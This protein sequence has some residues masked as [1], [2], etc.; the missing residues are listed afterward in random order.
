MNILIV[1]SM[2]GSGSFWAIQG[3]ARRDKARQEKA[4]ETRQNGGSLVL[5]NTVIDQ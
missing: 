3:K 2:Y 1:I 5:K 4:R